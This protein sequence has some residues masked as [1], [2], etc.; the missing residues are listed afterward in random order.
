MTKYELQAKLEDAERALREVSKALADILATAKSVNHHPNAPL[1]ETAP[2][3]IGALQVKV[4]F[5][6]ATADIA[7]GTL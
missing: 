6:Q 5:A 2:Y 1:E 7:L 4:S 3:I